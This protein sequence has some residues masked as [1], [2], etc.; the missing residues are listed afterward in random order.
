MIVSFFV[1]VLAACSPFDASI[2][3]STTDAAVSDAAV[4]DAGRPR[5]GG[6]S[7]ESDA[8]GVI[9]GGDG[10]LLDA[11]DAGALKCFD[12]RNGAGL[13]GFALQGAATI[14][15]AGVHVPVTA[16]GAALV[17]NFRLQN[18]TTI[19]TS[20]FEMEIAA[21]IGL[22]Q[23]GNGN[24]DFVDLVAQYYG[25]PPTYQGT[26]FNTIELAQG[27]TDLNVWWTKGDN[28]SGSFFLGAPLQSTGTATL[29]L[30][31]K[32]ASNGSI[33]VEVGSFS[34]S[35]STK[36][37]DTPQKKITLVIGGSAGG[38]HPSVN[39][40]VQRLCASLQ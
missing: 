13:Q 9:F 39:M 7:G 17:N 15:N 37:A 14:D 10:G 35:I 20:Y 2:V 21:T 34:K 3:P 31:T 33:K 29:K 30:T 12:F 26:A 28:F 36:V 18:E 23:F 27:G 19:T 25:D 24:G 22:E 6:A 16:S 4:D 40:I 1:A 5:D 8:S 38:M 11:G 32:W